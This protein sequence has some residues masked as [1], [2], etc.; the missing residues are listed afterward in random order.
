M[1]VKLKDK[2]FCAE[3]KSIIGLAVVYF[4]TINEAGAI[5]GMNRGATCNGNECKLEYKYSQKAKSKNLL[6]QNTAPSYA[7]HYGNYPSYGYN[8]NY[9]NAY[10]QYQTS[11]PAYATQPQQ[12]N[13]AYYPAQPANYMQTAYGYT[14]PNYYYGGYGQQ[15]R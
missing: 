9:Y 10:P 15:Y 12:S 2:N 13:Y 5:F 14:N 3:M 11:D 1:L 4:L 7:Y 6:A 8:Y